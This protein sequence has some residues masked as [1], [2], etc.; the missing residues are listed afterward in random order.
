MSVRIQEIRAENLVGDVSN[1]DI[2]WLCKV[3]DLAER[4]GRN[5]DPDAGKVVIDY[6]ELAAIRDL[7]KQSS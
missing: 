5:S 2:E 7:F 6:R 4:V 3:A 1:A